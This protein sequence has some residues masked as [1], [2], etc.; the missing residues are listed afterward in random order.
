MCDVKCLE[1]WSQLLSMVVAFLSAIST[2]YYLG[3]YF[4]Y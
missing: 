2:Y 1:V 3:N 4:V